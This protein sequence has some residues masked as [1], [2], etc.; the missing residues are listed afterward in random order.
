MG[1]ADAMVFALLA[2]ADIA[3]L[4]HLRRVRS[5]RIRAQRMMRCLAFAVRDEN[6]ARSFA[7]V[8]R[9][10]PPQRAG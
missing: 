6:A 8:A 2:L 4:I 3:F 9:R 7:A 10:G 5:R 1:S